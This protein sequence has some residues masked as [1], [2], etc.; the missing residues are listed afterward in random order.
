MD[1]EK[2]IPDSKSIL[3]ELLNNKNDGS[4]FEGG[5]ED[6]LKLEVNDS[7][8]NNQER[9]EREKTYIKLSNEKNLDNSNGSK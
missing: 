6:F 5:T 7:Y 3:D 4:H 2:F 9:I 8:K 1:V